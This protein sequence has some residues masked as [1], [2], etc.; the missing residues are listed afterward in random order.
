[1]RHNAQLQA[2]FVKQQG[3][4]NT[5]GGGDNV[6]VLGGASTLWTCWKAIQLCDW[7]QLLVVNFGLLQ[8]SMLI[9]ASVIAQLQNHSAVR[10]L[11]VSCLRVC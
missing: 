5:G 4:M 11:T 6:V 9:A 2:A 7:P 8:M 10:A 1:V 3:W